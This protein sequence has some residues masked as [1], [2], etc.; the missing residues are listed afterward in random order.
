MN[1]EV[2]VKILLTEGEFKTLSQYAQSVG[3][4]T[5][6]QTNYYY[7][8]PDEGLRQAGLTLRVR[9]KNG[10]ATLTLKVKDQKWET[11]AASR[12]FDFPI[13]NAPAT[14]CLDDFPVLRDEIEKRVPQ[15]PD[16]LLCLGSLTTTRTCFPIPVCG[17]TAELDKSSYFDC[18]DY[19]LE[20]ELHDRDEEA[21]LLSYLKESFSIT[22]QKAV[23][24]KYHRFLNRLHEI[25]GK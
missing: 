24:G 12:E 17:L 22:P 18:T 25:Q 2:E 5:V 13:E 8:L 10:K 9:T 20:C 19:E 11:G 7:D 3:G 6:E 23:C 1:H 14:L 16:T 21:S 4:Q 15:L